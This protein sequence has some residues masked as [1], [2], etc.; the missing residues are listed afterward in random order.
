MHLVREAVGK[1]KLE[2]ISKKLLALERVLVMIASLV[3]LEEVQS[4]VRAGLASGQ[5]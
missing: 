2:I 4:F 1:L 5:V 3:R